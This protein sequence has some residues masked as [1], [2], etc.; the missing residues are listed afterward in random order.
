MNLLEQ[1]ECI[2]N[3]K[4]V[5][6][7]FIE[8][9]WNSTVILL[10]AMDKKYILKKR[11]D[12]KTFIRENVIFD[13][14]G[15]SSF[16]NFMPIIKTKKN[17]SYFEFYNSFWAMYEYAG[18]EF[19]SL[20]YDNSSINMADMLNHL[21]ST[22]I[23]YLPFS[24]PPFKN[25]IQVSDGLLGSNKYEGVKAFHK[26]H[27]EPNL[28]ESELPVS[29]IHGDL[30]Q[31]NILYSDG[32]I[33]LIDFEF[34]RFDFRIYDFTSLAL[35]KRNHSGKFKLE[36]LRL[37]KE[38]MMLYNNFSTIKIQPQE[39]YYFFDYLF[40]QVFV[41]YCNILQSPNPCKKKTDSLYD[42]LNNFI[43]REKEYRGVFRNE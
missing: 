19:Y 15:K 9:S 35:G 41:I 34:S 13:K 18:N 42:V 37:V 25:N 24:L 16:T 26:N 28:K 23:K 11:L 6:A 20:H 17:K 33:K 4:A 43:K 36:E 21:H 29:F 3:V 5:K 10:Q 40:N 31:D 7:E 14:L 27:I 1:V 8:N 32:T 12:Y 38:V 22:N 30:N 2:Y 39:Y